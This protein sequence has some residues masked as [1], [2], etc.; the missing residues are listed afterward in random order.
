MQQNKRDYF[1]F[2][3]SANILF[4]RPGPLSA[5]ALLFRELEIPTPEVF[6]TSRCQVLLRTITRKEK[7]Q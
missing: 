1:F 2:S 3:L 6:L 4:L 5:D 7:S